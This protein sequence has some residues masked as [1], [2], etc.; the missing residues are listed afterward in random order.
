M[1]EIARQLLAKRSRFHG[2]IIVS[3]GVYALFVD[4]PKVFSALTVDKDQPLYIGM[5][6]DDTGARNHFN[7][8]A[9]HSGFSSPRR[10]IGAI[11]KQELKLHACRRA[12]GRSPTNWRNFR[13]SDKGEERLTRWMKRHLRM[14]LVPIPTGGKA[15]IEKIEQRLIAK[16]KP[17][18]NLKGWR[19]AQ[20]P[21][22]KA[23]RKTCSDE[24]R[25]SS[26]RSTA[27]RTVVS[28]VRLTSSGRGPTRRR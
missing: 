26:R 27:I 18:L 9:Q 23:L 22:V 21:T 10:S 2:G 12:N 4:D 5:T 24:A 3:S 19:N 14:N 25:D 20:A 8:P 17:P 15:K 13:F 11:L 16:L 6:A 28:T 1:E 7:P